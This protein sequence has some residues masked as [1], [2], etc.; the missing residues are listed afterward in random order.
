MEL[1]E[2]PDSLRVLSEAKRVLRPMGR[3]VLVS[4]NTS[5]EATFA[6]SAYN[7]IRRHL[8]HWIDCRPIDVFQILATAGYRIRRIETMSLWGL[9]VVAGLASPR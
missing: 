4:L 7:W 8:P 2:A 6:L 3:L 9:P 5:S 1:F